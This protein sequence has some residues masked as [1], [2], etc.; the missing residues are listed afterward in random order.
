MHTQLT[1]RGP[2]TAITPTQPAVLPWVPAN[3]DSISRRFEGRHPR[4]LLQWGATTFGEDIVMATGFGVSGIVLMHMASQLRTRLTVF[5]LQ[6]DLLFLETMALRSQLTERL[7]VRFVEVHSGLSLE[8]QRLQYGDKLW[9]SNPDLCCQLRKVNPLRR[10]LADKRAWI[11]GIRRDQ[12]ASRADAPLVSWDRAHD[13]V[14][15]NPL[16]GWTRDQV[17]TYIY[18]HQL[19]YNPLHDQGYPSLGCTHCT[20]QVKAG[21]PER[22]GRWA[23]FDKTECGI[24]V[25]PDG[26]IVR[27]SQVVAH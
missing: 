24:H 19:P 11:T 9:Q 23:G 1:Q 25:Q 13:L 27:T 21:D 8:D 12:S 5:F 4:E 16:A 18:Q 3:L 10:F 14:K 26:T 7:G 2:E 15:L 22:A 6:T 17:W 20:R